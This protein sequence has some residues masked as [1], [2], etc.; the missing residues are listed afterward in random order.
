[1]DSRK[2]LFFGNPLGV[3]E[4]YQQ[5]PAVQRRDV[6]VTHSGTIRQN[7]GICDAIKTWLSRSARQLEN[8]VDSFMKNLWADQL[9]PCRGKRL[10]LDFAAEEFFVINVVPKSFM[11]Q[12]FIQLGR[13]VLP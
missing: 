6:I 9:M 4:H 13:A 12:F 5:M 11:T 7:E 10:V 3:A 2:N 8:V 1:M